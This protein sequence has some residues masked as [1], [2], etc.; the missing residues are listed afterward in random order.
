MTRTA[1]ALA[2]LSWLLIPPSPANAADWA[3]VVQRTAPA[4]VNLKITVRSESESGGEPE[5]STQ[6]V[7]GALVDPSGLV[8]VWNSHFS[9]N[10]FLDLLAEM[11]GGDFKM[12]VTPTDIRV[13]LDGGATEHKAFLAA[14]DTDLD[15]AFVQIEEPPVPA[16]PAVDFSDAAP[17]RAG[18]ELAAVSR[19]SSAFDRVPYFD[20]VRVAGEIRKPRPAWIVTA[21]NATQLGMPYFAADGRAAG[22]LVTVMSKA[23]SDALSNPSNL[24]AD[25]ISLGRGEVEVGPLG[26]FLLPAEK[27]RSVIEQARQR[28]RELLAERAAQA[29]PQQPD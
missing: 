17:I 29:A 21:G 6:E 16:L 13:Y 7:Q 8:L 19:L 12:K 14:A 28:A 3:A 25:L 9:A 22:V 1:V 20:V 5:E 11:G 27:V 18:D 24:M 15:L 10:R 2:A 26:V 4:I 23:K